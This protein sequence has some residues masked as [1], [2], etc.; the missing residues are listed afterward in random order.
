MNIWLEVVN[1]VGGIQNTGKKT[2][3]LEIQAK[4]GMQSY[5]VYKYSSPS[6]EQNKKPQ[7]RIENPVKQLRWSFLGK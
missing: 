2:G 6:A 7:A 4:R 5:E 1:D 3:K